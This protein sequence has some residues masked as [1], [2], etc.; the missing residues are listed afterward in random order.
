MRTVNVTYYPGFV[1]SIKLVRNPIPTM[2]IGFLP[3]IVLSLVVIN[4]FDITVYGERIA[5]LAIIILT[6]INIMDQTKRDLPDIAYLTFSDKFY[7]CFI[8]LCVFPC[9]PD[10]REGAFWELFRNNKYV[11]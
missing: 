4:A 8:L 10:H 5:N 6:Y 7:L 9:I 2:M 11:I 3:A 1:F